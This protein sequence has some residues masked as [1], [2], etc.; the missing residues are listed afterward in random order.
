MT[1]GEMCYRIN[2]AAA[3]H[4]VRTGERPEVIVV[5]RDLYYIL[6]G[7]VMVTAHLIQDTKCI[8]AEERLFGMRLEFNPMQRGMNF[9]LGEKYDLGEPCEKRGEEYGQ[10]NQGEDH[11]AP[12][13]GTALAD[14]TESDPGRASEGSEFD[15]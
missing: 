1:P 3:M 7:S 5:S 6:Q 12:G 10:E 8:T 2:R 15:A 11:Q 4:E 13:R 14:R 9:I